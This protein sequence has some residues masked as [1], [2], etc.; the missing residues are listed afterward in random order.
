MG[1]ATCQVTNLLKHKINKQII[2]SSLKSRRPQPIH[3]INLN[4]T[5]ATYAFSKK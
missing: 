2:K 5:I 1:R 3:T 4:Y